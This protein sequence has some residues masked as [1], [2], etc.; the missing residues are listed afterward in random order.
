MNKN[1]KPRTGKKNI[2]EK[3]LAEVLKNYGGKPT[4][5]LAKETGIKFNTIRSISARKGLK[6][7]NRLWTAKQEKELLKRYDEYGWQHFADK[8][9]KT[10]WS[11]IN[12]FRELSGKRK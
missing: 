3:K 5:Q 1:P 8:F 10:K 12:K 9:D 11:V 7:E 6:K 2:S 4:K